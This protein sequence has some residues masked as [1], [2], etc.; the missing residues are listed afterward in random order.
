[1]NLRFAF[2]RSLRRPNFNET[3]PGAP[4]I[5]FTNLEFN[6]GNRLL[7]PSH[8]YNFDL[9]A[10]Y[11]FGNIGMVSAGV[12]GKLVTDH[13]FA[14]MSADVDQRTGIIFK[15]YQNAET[16]YVVG[17][18][19]QFN[20]RFDFLP[21][22]AKGFGINANY[23]YIHSRMNVPGRSKPQPLP[24]QADHL[25]NIALFYELHGVQARLALN[26][27]GPYLME[28]NLDRRVEVLCPIH[29]PDLRTHLRDVVLEAALRDTDRASLL[30]TDGRY[31]PPPLAEG[32]PPTSAQQLL[33]EHYTSLTSSTLL[34]PLRG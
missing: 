26:Y 15:S 22:F 12:F 21:G 24:R 3:K 13:I 32:E 5:D 23:T 31:K 19:A 18:E 30:E 10:E 6:T 16:S 14:T 27:R 7:R 25:F 34:E 11:F 1:M 29:Q 8:S 2:T 28:L 20:R 17:A 4:V 9:M 33:L